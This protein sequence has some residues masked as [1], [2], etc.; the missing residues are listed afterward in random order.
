MPTQIGYIFLTGKIAERG[1]K[2]NAI[3]TKLGISTKALSNKL[4]GRTEFT[5]GQTVRLQKTFF[6]D[7]DKDTLFATHNSKT[8]A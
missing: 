6:P 3:A 8:S 4:S 1:I 2:K 7:I 5:W